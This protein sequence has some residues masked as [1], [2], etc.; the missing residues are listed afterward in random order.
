MINVILISYRIAHLL[1]MEATLKNQIVNAAEAV[2][3]KVR[4]MRNIENNN[5]EVLK[6][7]FKPITD[8]LIQIADL[9]KKKDF[10]HTNYKK[11]EEHDNNFKW[12]KSA[13]HSSSQIKSLQ[14]IKPSLNT[15]NSFSDS[16]ID[17][18]VDT[19]TE[20]E[21]TEGE[22]Y[23]KSNDSFHT[24]DSEPSP[25]RNISSWS[26]S[27]EV[28]KDIPFGVRKEHGKLMM[29]SANVI[30]NDNCITIANRKYKRTLG[31]DELLLKKIPNL[32]LIDQDDSRNYK[33]MLLDTNAHR[34]DYDP[35]KPIK[36]NKGLK[37]LHVIKPLFQI[38]EQPDGEFKGKGLLP[39]IKKWKPNVDYVYWDNPNE[40]VDR[41]KLLVASRDAGNNGLN[42]EIISII[43]ELR[44]SGIVNT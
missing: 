15:E 20:N 25:N 9:D 28:F 13:S 10:K 14:D 22:E 12:D 19:E 37:Y 2:K 38:R 44:E 11:Y 8:P 1:K 5:E 35:I 29:G 3:R 40:L 43:E 27:S 34:R 39:L 7:V 16:E 21:E 32:T 33:Q 26:F 30:L 41:L 18:D 31:L 6:N 23:T 36:S 17:E 42:N 4:K 24:L